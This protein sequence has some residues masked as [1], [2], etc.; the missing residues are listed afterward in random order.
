MTT[1]PISSAPSD[2][3]DFVSRVRAALADLPPD[4]VD[5]LTAGLAADLA[6][7]RAEAPNG[8]RE[9]VGS[10]EAYAA[11]LRSAAGLPPRGPVADPTA[12]DGLRQWWASLATHPVAGPV[13]REAHDLAPAWWVIRGAIGGLLITRFVLG[14]GLFHVVTIVV[15][16]LGAAISVWLGRL[17]R[18]GGGPGWRLVSAICT[19]FALF[20]GFVMVSSS[21]YGAPASYDEPGVYIPQE[22]MFHGESVRNIYAYGPD[23]QRLDGVRLFD[24]RGNQLVIEGDFP[25]GV[26]QSFPYAA[27]GVMDPWA[28]RAED[29][30]WAPPMALTPLPGSSSTESST[31]TS[32]PTSSSSSSSSSGS[33]TKGSNAESSPKPTASPRSTASPSD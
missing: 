2:V 10:P 19:A 11:E 5:E 3:A 24:E 17:V 12:L 4:D 29:G 31:S 8:W 18:R 27:F 9:G 28:P 23:G 7:A 25:G 32:G 22:L 16:A 1:Q 15:V 26:Q 6:D 30:M 20:A 13:Q 14:L 33:T 21:R